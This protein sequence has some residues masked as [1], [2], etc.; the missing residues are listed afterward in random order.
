[1]RLM[2]FAGGM[3]LSGLLTACAQA[4]VASS[5]SAPEVND[6]V[7]QR[8]QTHTELAAHYYTRGQYAVALGELR[9]ALAA[10]SRYAP[11]HNMLGL[12][13]AE[14]KELPQAEASF[15]RA[16]ELTPNYSDVRNNYGHFLCQ[17]GRY[18]EGL[19]QFDAALRN[20]LYASPAVALANAGICST[21]KGDLARAGDYLQR[22][23]AHAPNQPIAL[24]AQAELDFLRGHTLAARNA[25]IKLAEL[26]ELDAAALW[27]GVRI[28]RKLGDRAAEASFGAQLRRRFPDA[29]P[30][31]LLINGIYEGNGQ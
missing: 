20:P 1:M 12:V 5:A 30:T 7:S 6:A 14:L 4:P 28:E 2:Q 17:R 22:A 31:K 19:A 24:R 16:I 29:A 3:L 13:H 26:T 23:L 18:D 21:A 11:A 9:I 15:R 8:A 27:L 25:L 10:D